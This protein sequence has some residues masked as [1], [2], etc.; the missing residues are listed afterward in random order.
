MKIIIDTSNKD[1]YVALIENG[2]T[3]R[4]KLHENLVKKADALPGTFLEVMGD[5]KAKEITDFYITL[6]PGSFTGART[7]LVFARSICQMTKANLHTT[8]SIQLIAGPNGEKE[9][10]I[11]ARSKKSYYAKV[12]NGQLQESITLVPFQDSTI[13]AFDNLIKNPEEYLSLF[14][15]EE[16]IF[17][18]HPYYIKDAKIGGN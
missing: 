13:Q 9:V 14:N 15:L 18:V 4:Y 11:D 10:F 16:D 6:G 17:N 1:L 7:G 8:S 12:K 2:K 3:L 5:I